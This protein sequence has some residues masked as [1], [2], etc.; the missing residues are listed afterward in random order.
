MRRFQPRRLAVTL[1]IFAISLGVGLTVAGG[2]FGPPPLQSV[3]IANEKLINPLLACDTPDHPTYPQFSA[4][5]Q[6]LTRLVQA[7]IAS[8]QAEKLSIFFRDLDSGRWAGVNETDTYSPASLFKVPL[9]VAYYRMAQENPNLL[10]AQYKFGGGPDTTQLQAI[11][12]AQKIQVGQ[13]Y[14]IGELIER[15]IVYSDNN[16]DLLL[17]NNPAINKKLL[18]DIFTDL[19]IRI[20]SDVVAQ[21]DFITA[22]AFSTFFTVLYNATYLNHAMSERALE[23]LTR[24]DFT[25]GLASGLPAAVPVAH[26]F[27][28][29]VIVQNNAPTGER[30]LHDC[31]IVYYPEHPYV[32]CLMSKGTSVAGLEAALQDVSRAVCADFSQLYSSQ[33]Y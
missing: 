14:S 4:M 6:E 10:N 3:P 18:E 24:T 1:A 7:K 2:A 32:L 26:K 17:F 9:M 8:H 15:M 5:E 27:G 29:R 20:P 31:G 25:K 11:E 12:P 22:R 21:G 30:E 33:T 13:T 28:E 19:H 23:L 16:A